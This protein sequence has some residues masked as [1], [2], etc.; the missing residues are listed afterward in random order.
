MLPKARCNSDAC[1]LSFYDAFSS[2]HLKQ[3]NRAGFALGKRNQRG[4]I[5]A[6]YSSVQANFVTAL[7][8]NI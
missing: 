8:L 7:L 4:V 6:K 5:A 3:E 1:A 2:S